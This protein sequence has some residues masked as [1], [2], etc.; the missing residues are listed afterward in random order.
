MK[1]KKAVSGGGPGATST[2][3][4]VGKHDEVSAVKQS[5]RANDNV[6]LSLSSAESWPAAV[7]S[8]RKVPWVPFIH[9][10]Y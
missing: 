6:M 1:V 4:L 5:Y 3:H 10:A 8:L 7:P 9:F 2:I